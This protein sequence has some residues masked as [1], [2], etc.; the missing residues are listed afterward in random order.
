MVFILIHLIGLNKGKAVEESG[1]LKI[2]SD[3]D[4][5]L[6]L[7]RSSINII[8]G[9]VI[10]RHI[11]KIP[12]VESY[13]LASAFCLSRLVNRVALPIVQIIENS[14]VKLASNYFPSSEENVRYGVKSTVK[15]ASWI[16]GT[17][18][19]REVFSLKHIPAVSAV[20]LN[21]FY[22]ECLEV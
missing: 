13:V 8:C 4:F 1:K 17:M 16:M 18:V 19:I 15:L 14:F 11:Y 10:G 20:S 5:N 22:N 6:E 3:V 2:N 21:V 7:A 9:T 12:L